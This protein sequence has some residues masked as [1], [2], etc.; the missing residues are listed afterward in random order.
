M[1][2]YRYMSMKEFFLM[3]S[4]KTITGKAYHKAR[5]ESE[6]V[7]FL[8]EDTAFCVLMDDGDPDG[9]QLEYH[10]NP[11]QCW[12]FLGGIV[13]RDVL[14]EFEAPEDALTVSSGTYARPFSGMWDEECIEITEYCA[15]SYNREQFVPL[16]YCLDFEDVGFHDQPQWYDY[17]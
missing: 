15:R 12:E 1:K 11:V 8:G 2:I 17:H 3:D 7:C 10:F 14:V 13:S 9:E 6:G 5:T 16:R 4:F